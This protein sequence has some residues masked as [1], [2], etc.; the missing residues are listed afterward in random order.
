MGL[1]NQ[2]SDEWSRALAYFEHQDDKARARH[3]RR[4][5]DGRIGRRV[6]GR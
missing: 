1:Y 4:E 3:K 5:F 2:P 6:K